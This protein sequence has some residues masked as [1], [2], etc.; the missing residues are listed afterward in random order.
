[1]VNG[2]Q[3]HSVVRSPMDFRIPTGNTLSENYGISEFPNL[4]LMAS[5][6]FDAQQGFARGLNGSNGA[7]K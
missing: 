2:M 5:R 1:M 4:P 7:A 3:T 6:N